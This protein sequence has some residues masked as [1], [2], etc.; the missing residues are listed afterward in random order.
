AEDLGEAKPVLEHVVLEQVGPSGGARQPAA[1]RQPRLRPGNMDDELERSERCGQR[2][3]ADWRLALRVPSR[4]AEVGGCA[5]AR[6]QALPLLA[7]RAHQQLLARDPVEH[8]PARVAPDQ[9][10]REP[11]APG[12]VPDD[13]A[14]GEALAK[15]VEDIEQRA[16]EVE[17]ATV[18]HVV[19]EVGRPPVF[20]CRRGGSHD[21]AGAGERMLAR[22]EHGQVMEVLLLHLFGEFEIEV[23]I[24][25]FGLAQNRDQLFRREAGGRM[26]NRIDIAHARH[27]GRGLFLAQALSINFAAVCVVECHWITRVIYSI[28]YPVELP[29]PRPFREGKGSANYWMAPYSWRSVPIGVVGDRTA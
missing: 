1:Q 18:E 21:D 15:R 5:R 2:L 13:L 7:Q 27:G 6:R 29:N 9:P 26:R 10:A 14:G 17:D 11:F 19:D 22:A 20:G 25:E 3:M 4:A 23:G 12:G 24:A 16:M 8:E 28:Q